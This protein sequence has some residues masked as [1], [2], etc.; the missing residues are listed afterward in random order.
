MSDIQRLTQMIARLDTNQMA[1]QAAIEEVA[2][3][4]RQRGSEAVADNVASALQV[5]SE[6][7]DFIGKGI[8]DL[9]AATCA[10]K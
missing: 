8:A 3:W 7:A 1:L 9:T 6:N 5:L 10:S 4:I 2:S